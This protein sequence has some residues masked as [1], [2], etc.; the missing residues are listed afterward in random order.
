MIVFFIVII[1]SIIFIIYVG[2]E[3]IYIIEYGF[4][5]MFVKEIK[6]KELFNK[7]ICL[8]IV[9]FFRMLYLEKSVFVLDIY[10]CIDIL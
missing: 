9:I 5:N 7:L 4:K 6:N 8:M 1:S 3:K 2:M 10:S